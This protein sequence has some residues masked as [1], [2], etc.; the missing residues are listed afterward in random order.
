MKIRYTQNIK[1][2][3]FEEIKI[4]ECCEY[5]G[6]IV[7]RIPFV[8]KNSLEINAVNLGKLTSDASNCL[9]CIPSNTKVY[10]VQTELMVTYK[11]EEIK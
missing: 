6:E 11:C 9:L 1:E 5:E 4:G 3:T 8:I 7:F 2:C 10:P